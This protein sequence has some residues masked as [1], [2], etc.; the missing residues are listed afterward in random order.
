[1]TAIAG[2]ETTRREA[3]NSRPTDP[4]GA[5]GGRRSIRYRSFVLRYH[6]IHANNALD[7]SEFRTAPAA[8]KTLPSDS[9]LS[10]AQ[11]PRECLNVIVRNL[12][13]ARR[14]WDLSPAK[15][16]L[17]NTPRQPQKIRAD[18]NIN[19][20][21]PDGIPAGNARVGEE[22]TM[23]QVV[24]SVQ[25]PKHADHHCRLADAYKRKTKTRE[26]IR[27]TA[28]HLLDDHCLLARLQSEE[29]VEARQNEQ[30]QRIQP[31]FPA[32]RSGKHNRQN[33][34]R[35]TNEGFHRDSPFR[36]SA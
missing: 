9:A 35:C 24:Q 10:M 19:R 34:N 31:G 22:L 15:I 32:N 26:N 21:T 3:S 36:G 7:R 13:W 23:H 25:Q 4:P 8:C 16:C 28:D 30:S 11:G 17:G 20:K 27:N 5:P 33:A 12:G 29:R 1:M 6:R 18:D 14:H 2:R